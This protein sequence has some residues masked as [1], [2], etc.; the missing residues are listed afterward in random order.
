M[1]KLKLYLETSLICSTIIFLAG[2]REQ[3]LNPFYTKEYVVELAEINGA[4][5]T[6]EDNGR[7]IEQELREIWR[8]DQEKKNLEIIEAG[9]VTSRLAMTIFQIGSDY[10]MDLTAGDL[11]NQTVGLN[12]LNHVMPTHSLYKIE[13]TA[14]NLILLP[15]DFQWLKEAVKKQKF[16]LPY[17]DAEDNTGLFTASPEEWIEFLEKNQD[18]DQAFNRKEKKIFLRNKTAEDFFSAYQDWQTFQENLSVKVSLKSD[19]HIADESYQRITALGEPVLPLLIAKIESGAKNGWPESEFFLWH[20]IRDITGVDLSKPNE[21]LGES[22]IALRYL[23]W[24]REQLSKILEQKF[25][26]EDAL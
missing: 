23:G 25:G 8:V 22:E 13:I 16:Q 21:F 4:W 26:Q 3:A 18:L 2:C 9:A 19:D 17:A 12:W 7:K 10:F 11:A 14:D 6:I 15:F 1:K 24:W 5:E 20:A